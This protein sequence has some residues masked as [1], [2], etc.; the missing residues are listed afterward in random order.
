MPRSINKNGEAAFIESRSSIFELYQASI[1]IVRVGAFFQP[2]HITRDIDYFP[3]ILNEMLWSQD[4]IEK[5]AQ[6]YHNAITGITAGRINCFLLLDGSPE[7]GILLHDSGEKL[8]CA[9]YPPITH[10]YI[11]RYDGALRLL[12]AVARN[13]DGIK[14]YLPENLRRGQKSL[15][16]IMELI[17]SQLKKCGG[18][19][20]NRP[21]LYLQKLIVEFFGGK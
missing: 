20:G 12:E 3:G 4:A 17:I 8:L 11:N 9:Y 13:T 15:K 18:R 14:V 2:Y 16:E 7:E 10:D 1:R 5:L 21:I 19:T 6:E